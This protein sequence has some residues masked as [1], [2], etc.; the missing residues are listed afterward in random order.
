MMCQGLGKIAAVGDPLLELALLAQDLK[1]LLPLGL[2]QAATAAGRWP[3]M[4]KPVR[5]EFGPGP[6]ADQGRLPTVQ[7]ILRRGH[8]Y[9]TPQVQRLEHLIHPGPRGAARP[10][11]PPCAAYC[12]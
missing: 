11:W 4:Q 7:P 1:V 12:E 8:D 10:R 5:A 9:R 6:L 3:G 2:G